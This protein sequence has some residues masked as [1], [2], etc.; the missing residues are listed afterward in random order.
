MDKIA[1]QIFQLA[2]DL[3]ARHSSLLRDTDDEALIEL[4]RICDSPESSLLVEE[5]LTRFY[6]LEDDLYNDILCDIANHIVRMKYD[7]TQTALVAMAHDHRSDSSQS[8]LYDIQIPLKKRGFS[9]AETISRFD[10]I[11]KF[12]QK[13]IRNFVVVDDFVGSGKTVLIR[14]KELKSKKLS[15]L[16]LEFCFVAGMKWAIDK[17]HKKAVAL[18]CP[19]QM[20]KAISEEYGRD[21][22]E[23][24]CSTM[25]QLEENL[26]ES[27]NSL[28]LSEHSFGYH[29]AEAVFCRRMHN[30]PN[31]VFPLFWWK[32]Y[33]DG[34]MR[35]TVFERIQNGY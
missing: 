7:E 26:A 34:S 18:Y 6:Y 30:I 9:P 22:R 24:K 1:Y 19:W 29:Q 10:R 23:R 33:K 27:I 15:G 16:Y 21:L 14:N 32:Q 5:L 4:A 3:K 8:V 28:Q 11:E 31:S 35:K 13:G 20:K 25:K 2:Y 12:Y 17:C